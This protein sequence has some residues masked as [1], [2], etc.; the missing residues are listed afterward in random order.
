MSNSRLE[1]RGGYKLI[2]QLH[3]DDTDL[4]EEELQSLN[5]DGF[6]IITKKLLNPS[7]TFRT[8]KFI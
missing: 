8:S 2:P 4:S 7:V 1:Q 6:Q 5:R 3:S